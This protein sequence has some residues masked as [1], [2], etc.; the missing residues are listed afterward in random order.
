MEERLK[1]IIEEIEQEKANR[2]NPAFRSNLNQPSL[3]AVS[4][5]NASRGNSADGFST[6]TV[7]LPRPILEADTLELLNANIPQCNPNIPDTAC[8]FW[9]YRLNEYSGKVPTL[10][11]LYCVR[12]LPSYYKK[13]F[14]SNAGNY[15]YNQTFNGY[16]DV[17]S[18]LALS[19]SN[20]LG[21]YNYLNINT[22]T[23][24]QSSYKSQFCPRDVL[25]F[26]DSQSNK[27]RMTGNNADEPPVF[28]AWDNTTAYVVGDRVVSSLYL[29]S[30]PDVSYLCIQDNTNQ[31]PTW[32]SSYWVPDNMPVL[33]AWSST[34]SYGVGRLVEYN[35][36]IYI[37]LLSTLNNQ[38]DVSPTYWEI[39]DIST[40][41]FWNR[42]LITG[43]NDPN[44]AI[45]QGRFFQL[46]DPYTLFEVDTIVEYQGQFYKALQQ[47]RGI[48]PP[49]V[50]YW[51]LQST[52]ISTMTGNGL[53]T[54]IQCDNSSGL[55]TLGASVYIIDSTNPLFNTI[56]DYIVE[57]AYTVSGVTATSVTI[58]A[59]P[60][61]VGTSTGG[62][63][64]LAYPKLMG[65]NAFS[66]QFDMNV[67]IDSIPVGIPPQPFNP[68]PRRLLNSILGFTWNGQMT[69]SLLA[70]IVPDAINE[71]PTTTTELYNRLRPVPYYVVAPLELLGASLEGG[72]TATT[73]TADGYCNLVYSSTISIYASIVGG[74]TLDSQENT[75][76]LALGSMNC[77][78][79]GIAFFNQFINNPLSVNGGDIYTITIELRDE[80]GE[81]YV[82]TN[83]AVASF[84]FKITYKK[85]QRK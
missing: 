15:G 6:F 57:D 41:G 44:V 45:A 28:E 2:R 19:C 78:N 65:L 48:T 81:P 76:L 68:V 50:G 27:F 18:Q 53:T 37:S 54:T 22:P 38:P 31:K 26:Y 61:M 71:I 13:E 51:S 1:D 55:I 36:D 17:A 56:H 73:Y 39:Y 43:Y 85:D 12:L 72:F 64:C 10:N 16:T 42:Y 52:S 33:A 74:S 84:V 24:V 82:L 70:N 58:S 30:G 21:Y 83:N 46:Y 62:V 60:S 4:S 11:N 8:A 77:G 34:T 5:A 59:I 9:Y 80:F 32:A 75:N 14:I 7:N 35:G 66:K 79:L 29:A 49:S 20:D 63:L 69:P 40:S 3:V 23:E 67:A 47:T 25:V